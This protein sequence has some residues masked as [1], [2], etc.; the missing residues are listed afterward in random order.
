MILRLFTNCQGQG[1]EYFLRRA[2]PSWDIKCFPHLATFYGEF[3]DALLA[4][5]HW[6]ADIVFYHHKHD[7]ELDYPTKQ[8]K[9]PL[10]VWYQSAPFMAQIPEDLWIEFRNAGG[11]SEDAVHHDFNYASRFEFCCHRMMEKEDMEL[12]PYDLKMSHLNWDG[13]EMQY[14]LT[15][16][17]PT[18]IIFREWSKLI[19]KYLDVSHNGMP[20]VD[21]CIANPNLAGLP[22]EESA[23]SGAR[24][25]LGLKWGGRPEDDESGR[26]IARERLAKLL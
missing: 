11:N 25:H 3:S 13:R 4:E 10:S 9:I 14:Q 24:K 22:C 19:C 15:C 17:H 5:E 20:S 7:G 18:S 1:L 2:L 26:Q 12:V 23:T 21:E 16:N 6:N 8:P